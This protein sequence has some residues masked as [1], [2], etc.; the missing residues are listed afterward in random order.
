MAVKAAYWWKANVGLQDAPDVE[1]QD[2]HYEKVA[3]VVRRIFVMALGGM[4]CRKVAAMLNEG[5]VLT[6][7]TYCDWNMAEKVC[8]PTC[9]PATAFLK[10]YRTKP[11][12][13]NVFP[14]LKKALLL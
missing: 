2:R 1:K 4:S 8:M 9:G 14:F 7:A 11:K 3:A 13:Y 10:S 12:W 6:Q 5:G